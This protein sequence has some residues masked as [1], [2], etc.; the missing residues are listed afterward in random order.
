MTV[1][2]GSA[3]MGCGQKRPISA[4]NGGECSWIAAEVQDEAGMRPAET[5]TQTQGVVI[6][7]QELTAFYFV[8]SSCTAPETSCC[9]NYL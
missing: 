7:G 1:P 8:V 5:Q 4:I 9:G 2:M 3:M 6:H